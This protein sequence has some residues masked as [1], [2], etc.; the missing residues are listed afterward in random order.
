[1]SKDQTV[2]TYK[3]PGET[4]SKEPGPYGPRTKKHEPKIYSSLIKIHVLWGSAPS[5]LQNNKMGYWSIVCVVA[6]LSQL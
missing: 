4:Y 5:L 1:M 2:V 6:C 3:N